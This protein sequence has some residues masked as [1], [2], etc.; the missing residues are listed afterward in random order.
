VAY[1]PDWESLAD[2]LKR[3]IAADVASLASSIA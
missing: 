2:A 3:V 1:I